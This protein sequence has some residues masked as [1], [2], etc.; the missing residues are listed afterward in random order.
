MITEL[1]INRFTLG[2][3]LGSLYIFGT[4]VLAL[5]ILLLVGGQL[6]TQWRAD[7]LNHSSQIANRLAQDS[8]L[9]LIQNS[10]ENV[11]DAVRM[12][13]NYPNVERIAIYACNEDTPL[14]GSIPDGFKRGHPCTDITDSTIQ[15]S[16]TR[17]TIATPVIFTASPQ[18]PG[19][20]GTMRTNSLAPDRPLGCVFLT[21]S[22]SGMN[23]A[24][25]MLEKH[26]L[27]GI[28]IAATVVLALI[29]LTMTW[30][31]KPFRRLKQIMVKSRTGQPFASAQVYGIKEARAIAES[32]NALMAELQKS[33]Y[34][35]EERIQERTLQL[36]KASRAKSEFLAR[37]SHEIRTPM[38]GILGFLSALTKTPL[39]QQQ[40]K[41][42]ELA[43][44][45]IQ[46]LVILLNDILD[47]A[48]IEAGKMVLD[49][50]PF[51]LHDTISNAAFIHAESARKKG[52]GL[53]IAIDSGTPNW[54]IGDAVRWAQIVHNLVHNAVKY[55]YR[56]EITIRLRRQ[57]EREEPHCLEL[58]VRDTG[59]GIA[60]QD[61][62]KVFQ[63]FGQIDGSVTRQQGG[64]GLGLA[65]CKSWVAAMGGTLALESQEGVGSTFRICVDVVTVTS[66]SAPQQTDVNV[67]VVASDE[68]LRGRVLVVDDN[69]TNR[70][71][72][73]SL[74]HDLGTVVD[75]ASNGYE[76][77]ASCHRACYDLILMDWRM[78]GLDGIETTKHLRQLV[79]NPNRLTP[80][81]GITADLDDH[82]DSLLQAGMNAC[83]HKPLDTEH[84]ISV[85]RQWLSIQPSTVSH[86]VEDARPA[87]DPPN[88]AL[89][90]AYL[91]K[92]LK[93][94]PALLQ[95]LIEDFKGQTQHS[96]EELHEVLFK[97][98]DP[99]NCRVV[100]HDLRGTAANLGALNVIQ[101]CLKIQAT[102]DKQ[103]TIPDKTAFFELQESIQR[104]G[105][106]LSQYRKFLV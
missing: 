90:I 79:G 102:L 77:L 32:Y 63:L 53:K 5:V 51:N 28:G 105:E 20:S 64:S 38:Q 16:T 82:R 92:N 72:I 84:L 10:P 60:D 35:L 88:H 75:E 67:Q 76:A 34:Q 98:H 30:I 106:A 101:Q 41:Y 4:F 78:P 74:L 1:V 50:K 9:A 65:N 13:R 58:T 27:I 2:Q 94:K 56:G 43:Q 104:A 26:L 85:F 96:L 55:T 47:H 97:E 45:S 42:L 17:L 89:D 69:P 12:V 29:L 11:M 54:I 7:L 40:T 46:Q 44:A 91:D 6:R 8:R 59:I 81:I 62:K 99:N 33:N 36:Q 61:K 87:S 25:N 21:V 39:S 66:L 52:L 22:K 37:M 71:L 86:A 73:T 23:N 31:T 93:H 24:I 83:L 19:G 48:R 49:N 68:T 80:I 95:S 70:C 57:A 15:E 100:L 14:V 103:R 3:I 18:H